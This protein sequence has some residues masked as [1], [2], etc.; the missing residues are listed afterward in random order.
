MK[1][2]VPSSF[3]RSPSTW[4]A[5]LR[6]GHVRLEIRDQSQDEARVFNERLPDAGPG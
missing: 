2:L 6:E 4:T 1:R 5:E 3:H